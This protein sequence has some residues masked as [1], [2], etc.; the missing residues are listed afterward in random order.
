MSTLIFVSHPEVVI[1]GTVP[2]PEWG[3]SETGKT[4]AK[5]FAAAH[6]LDGVGAIWSS[7]EVKALDTAEILAEPSGLK[8]QIDP[9]LGENDRSATGFIPP[10]Q[11][12]AAADAFFASP[13]TSFKGW[14]RAVDAQDRIVKAVREIAR[15]HAA[16]DL[17]IS[18]HGGVGTLLYCALVGASIDRK[19][20]QAG[21]GNYWTA[22]LPDLVPIHH[23]RTIG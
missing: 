2:V 18:S 10:D 20:D 7:A 3:L 4:R 6:I 5:Q 23:W 22:R 1:D 14:E 15:S 16:G 17:V 8:V 13:E 11:F 19:F 12:Q 9:R 21:Q